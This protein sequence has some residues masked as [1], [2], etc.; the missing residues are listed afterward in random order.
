[1]FATLKEMNVGDRGRVAAIEIYNCA[2]REQLMAMGLTR[3]AQ[4]TLKRIAPLGD[5]VEI[6]VRGFSLSLRKADAD[7]VKVE[8]LN[9]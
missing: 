1:M 9:D 6:R 2:Y 7:G 4:F 8:P 5:P 3:G